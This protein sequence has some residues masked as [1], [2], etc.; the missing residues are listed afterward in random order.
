MYKYYVVSCVLWNIVFWEEL[1][2]I[3]VPCVPSVCRLCATALVHVGTLLTMADGR[4]LAG[5]QAKLRAKLTEKTR[6]RPY[7]LLRKRMPAGTKEL[8][9]VPRLAASSRKAATAQQVQQYEVKIRST[10]STFASHHL[11]EGTLEEHD[12]YVEWINQWATL[13]GFGTFIV[14]DMKVRCARVTQ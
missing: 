12:N 9:A 8:A 4:F 1:A 13:S 14:M 7:E 11:D 5:P 3:C 2:I 10:S 6:H